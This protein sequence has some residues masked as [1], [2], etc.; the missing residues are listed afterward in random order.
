MREKFHIVA[1]KFQCNLQHFKMNRG[2]LRHEECV[3]FLHLLGEFSSCEIFDLFYTPDGIVLT[4]FYRCFEGSKSY[5]DSSGV[6]SFVYLDDCVE[7]VVLVENFFY[8]IRSDCIQS[9]AE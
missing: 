3:F 4:F 1:V 7:F 5:S 8:L 2:H 9:A 6:G